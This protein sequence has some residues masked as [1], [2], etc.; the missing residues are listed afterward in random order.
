M[1]MF[2]WNTNVPRHPVWFYVVLFVCLLN[3]ANLNPE[4]P[5]DEQAVNMSLSLLCLEEREV[6][7]FPLCPHS[8]SR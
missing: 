8:Q 1:R 6:W 2:I 3:L 5:L 7:D 4:Q